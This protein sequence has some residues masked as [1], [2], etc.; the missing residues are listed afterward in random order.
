MQAVFRG[1]GVRGFLRGF[2]RGFVDLLFVE[3]L[4][5]K[6]VGHFH[7]RIHARFHFVS[8]LGIAM[9]MFEK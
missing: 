9:K 2:S 1:D 5:S 6:T 4:Q 3:F 8:W 7:E